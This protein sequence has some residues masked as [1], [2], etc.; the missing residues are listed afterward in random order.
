MSSCSQRIPMFC[1]HCSE[2][3]HQTRHLPP[4]GAHSVATCVTRGAIP[5]SPEPQKKPPGTRHGASFTFGRGFGIVGTSSFMVKDTK[6]WDI[7]FRK[8][9][10]HG[11]VKDVNPN[12]VRCTFLPDKRTNV[13]PK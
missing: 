9:L 11:V 4:S 1:F 8:R 6:T 10:W 12:H 2:D 3:V 7:F 13:C 5:R